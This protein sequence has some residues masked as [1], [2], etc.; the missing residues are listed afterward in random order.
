MHR[1]SA[2]SLSDKPRY[3]AGDK[4]RK[5]S[6]HRLLLISTLSKRVG[7]GILPKNRFYVLTASDF[8]PH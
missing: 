6:A 1:H 2:R 3:G 4:R 5:Q 8:Y 7:G